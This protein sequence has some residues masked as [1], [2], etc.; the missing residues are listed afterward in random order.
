[1]KKNIIIALIAACLG[2]TIGYLLFNQPA[3]TPDAMQ[4]NHVHEETSG[5]ETTWTCSMHPQIRQNEPGKCPICEMDLIP[6]D[7]TRS[8]DP[9]VL[10]MTRE[11]VKLAQVRTTTIGYAGGQAKAISLNGKIQADERRAAS[12]VSHLPGRIEALEVTFTGEEVRKGQKIATLYSPEFVNAQ[13]ELLV[14]Q[15]LTDKNPELLAAARRKLSY[16]KI[17]E[18]TIEEILSSGEIQEQIDVYAESSGIVTRRRVAVGD[19]VATGGVLFDI[20]DLGRLWVIFDA[21]EEDLPSIRRGDLVEFTTPVLPGQQ[22][23]TRITYIDPVIDPRKRTAAV[24][25]EVVNRGGRLKPEMLVRGVL[26]GAKATGDA[27]LAVPKSAVLWTGKRSVVYVAVPGASVPSYAYREVTLG[28]ALGD[29]YTVLSGLEA[30]EEVVTNGAFTIDAAAQL[31][32]QQSMMNRLVSVEGAP[33]TI[34]DYRSETPTTFQQQIKVVAD[35]Y[36]AVKD[37]LVATNAGQASRA[38]EA[39][40]KELNQVEMHLLQ[41]PAHDFWMQQ[42]KALQAH[43]G[44]IATA[45]E[46]EKERA[47]FEFLSNAMIAVAKAFGIEG[48]QAYIQHCPMAF[49]NRGADWLSFEEDI[50]NPYFGDEML[51]CGIVK[52]SIEQ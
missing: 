11:A 52:D 25:A 33:Q 51:T 18:A 15:S 34:P 19:Y 8:D 49:N 17:P 16:W 6:L 12:L 35:A 47:Q 45:T 22:F 24:R 14:A 50:L 29:Q 4:D 27:A 21:Y 39:F 30:G 48:Q 41:G 37:A 7:E 44:Q 20:I 13:R 3:D 23:S 43:A 28:E 2:L 10:Q 9:L 40:L 46:V 32:N 31:N 38:A 26:L 42:A 1:M 36:T 5:E